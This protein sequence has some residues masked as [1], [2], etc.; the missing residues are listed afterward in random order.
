MI[1]ISAIISV[2]C[3]A[4]MTPLDKSCQ[5]YLNQCYK[6]DMTAEWSQKYE[7]AYRKAIVLENCRA[8]GGYV[9]KR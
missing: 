8:K 9:P 4:Y 6:M 5:N 7:V 3:S 1:L 2:A